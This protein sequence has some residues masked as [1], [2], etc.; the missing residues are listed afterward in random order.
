MH[1]YVDLILHSL[2]K[3]SI[4][5]ELESLTNSL[6]CKDKTLDCFLRSCD[7][8]SISGKVRE[9]YFSLEKSGKVR[10]FQSWSGNFISLWIYLKTFLDEVSNLFR[11]VSQ[12][13]TINF[14][15]LV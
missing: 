13:T 8:V 6:M 12:T 7:M 5:Y 14:I 3:Y 4:K 11:D 1:E 2:R 10:E 15:S 9:F